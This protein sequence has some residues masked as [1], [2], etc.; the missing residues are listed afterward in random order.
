VVCEATANP[1]AYADPEVCGAS[2]AFDA[3]HL[4][5]DAALG[6]AEAV[7]RLAG[8]FVKAPPTMA[9]FVSNHDIFGG[10][11]LWD[12]VGGDL[13]AYRLAAAGYLLLPGTPFIYY[14]EEVGQA[15]AE[16]LAGDGPIR[17]PMSWSADP[18][19]AGFTSGRPFRPVAPNAAAFNAAAEEKDP[20][21][22]LAFY[23]AMLALRNG[24]RSIAEGDYEAPFAD[25]LVMGYRR[26]LGAE[27][28]LVVFNYGSLP[29]QAIVHGLAPQTALRP[30]WPAG[31]AAPGANDEG[32]ALVALPARSL[33]VYDLHP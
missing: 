28:T 31:A 20:D 25:G 10:K 2:F 21:S 14:G 17:S 9:T 26:R 7:Q 5:V 33:A 29:A 1:P 23:K 24:R 32:D 22:I 4:F 3:A 30:L 8:Y 12:Q 13:A 16:G 15:S 18:A 27:T 19:N 11:R 6:K